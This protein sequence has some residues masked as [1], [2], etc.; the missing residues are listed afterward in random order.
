MSK[1][2]PREIK[3]R[4]NISREYVYMYMYVRI[5]THTNTYLHAYM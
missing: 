2:K 5:H 4:P 1:L 3:D